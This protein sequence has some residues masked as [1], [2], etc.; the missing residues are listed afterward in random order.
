MRHGSVEVRQPG[1][2]PSTG[3]KGTGVASTISIEGGSLA[4]CPACGY[5]TLS[6]KLCAFCVPAAAD[7]I[8]VVA[9]APDVNPAA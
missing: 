9:D 6:P 4:I 8:D 3:R 2:I 5:P 7:K 1:Y